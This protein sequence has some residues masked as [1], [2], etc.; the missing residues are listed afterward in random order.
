[1]GASVEMQSHLLSVIIFLPLLG[2]PALLCCVRTI[3]SGFAAS[4]WPSALAEFV[5]SLAF[6]CAASIPRIRPISSSRIHRWIGDAIH[7]HLGVDGISLFLVLLTTFLTPLAILCSWKSI[8]EIR[9]GLLH[10]AAGD[11]NRP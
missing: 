5:I 4:R 8:H 2:V 7:Y 9:Q 11:R 1:M 3:T 10:R 6:C